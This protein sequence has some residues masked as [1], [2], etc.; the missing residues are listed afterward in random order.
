MDWLLV[1]KDLLEVLDKDELEAIV[2]HEVSHIFNR[3]GVT[4]L[5]TFAIFY[6][7]W[8]SFHFKY[9]FVEVFTN[10]LLSFLY[11]VSVIW[12]LIGIRG[13]NWVSTKLEIY[14]DI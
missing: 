10:P 11:L 13:V 8:L 5:A 2:A 7:P 12:F 4:M 3:H 1:T 14:A 6:A 9:T